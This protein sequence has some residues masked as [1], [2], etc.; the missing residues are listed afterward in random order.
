MKKFDVLVIG[1]GPAGSALATRL[2]GAGRAVAVLEKSA[3][4]RAKVCGEFIAPPGVRQLEQLGVALP[5]GEPVDRIALWAGGLRIDAPLAPARALAREVLDALVLERAVSAGA[6]LYQPARALAVTRTGEG[7]IVQA[8]DGELEA[9][10]VVAAHGSWEPGPLPTQCVRPRPAASDVFGFKAHFTRHRLP[11]RTIGLVPFAGGYAGAVALSGA[12]ATFACSVRR[13]ALRALRRRHGGVCAGEAVFQHV[14]DTSVAVHE[15]FAAAARDGPW[16]AVGPLRPGVRRLVRDGIF[17]V[18]NAAG[19]VHPI[20]GEGITLA[21]ESA[22]AL[23][24]A[25]QC[26][27]MEAAREYQRRYSPVLR[28]RLWRSTLL[29]SVASNPALAAC[30][31]EPLRRM[32]SLLALAARA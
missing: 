25:L 10:A 18:G 32:P 20:V 22:S 31:R 21:L 19:E 13:D 24:S 23:A 2:A 3:F 27:P 26:R 5:A 12:A 7:F 6:V 28:R 14:V 1:A 9:H 16:L 17:A 29:A 11:A 30:V 15:A 4:P 8:S